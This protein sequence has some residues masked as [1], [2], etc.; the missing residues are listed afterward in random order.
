MKR[1]ICFYGVYNHKIGD[2]NIHLHFLYFV[3]NFRMCAVGDLVQVVKF[4]P[5]E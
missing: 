5:G 2:F 1:P 4:I 3:I